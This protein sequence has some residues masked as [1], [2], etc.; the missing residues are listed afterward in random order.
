M[1]NANR[2][3]YLARV[4]I[5]GALSRLAGLARWLA[6]NQGDKI[7]HMDLWSPVCPRK[8]FEP[9]TCAVESECV[10]GRRTEEFRLSRKIES[11]SSIY[12]G[13]LTAVL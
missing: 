4:R 2:K 13:I 1:A 12:R 8:D 6:T 7:Y 11:D 3:P 9:G 10:R 5:Q